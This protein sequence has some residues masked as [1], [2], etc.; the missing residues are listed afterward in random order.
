[1]R[2]DLNKNNQ[3]I[4][5]YA[6][7]NGI[8]YFETCYFYLNH[9]CEDYVYSLLKK[10][11]RSTYEICGKLSLAEAF[12]NNLQEY[13]IMYQEQLKKVPGHYFDV[14]LLQT[15]RPQAY[16]K[17]YCSDLLEFFDKEKQKG[18]IG[19][20]GF[21]EQ[22]DSQLLK[23]F[24][25]YPNWDIAQM[26]LNYY[27]WYLC[28]S[29]TNY[30]LITQHNIPIIAQAPL[31]GGE[32]IRGMCDI[33]G[34]E[35]K[36]PLQMAMDFVNDKQPEIILTGCSQLSTLKE[37]HQAHLNHSPCDLQDIDKIISAYKKIKTIP[38]LLCAKC[39]CPKGIDIPLHFNAYNRTLQN[40]NN[41]FEVANLRYFS[42]DPIN[43]CDNC[44]YC[45]TMCPVSLNIP[46]Y[47]MDV[48]NLRP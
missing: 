1:M 6:M 42:P 2:H 23:Q 45:T 33:P 15:L 3:E 7:S 46:N 8:T 27:D 35:T 10:Y 4:I 38:C 13:K 30:E 19:R 9:C 20:F 39:K 37:C 43:I 16:Y 11:P 25:E 21:S 48:F 41:F 28:A 5:E 29:D 12:A 14:Y 32:L 26:P 36:T 22:C 47:F 24:L 34:F 18:N 31:K 44:N 17:I 40:K